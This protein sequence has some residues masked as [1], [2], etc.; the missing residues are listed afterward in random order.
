M[1][2][3][4]EGATVDV[5]PAVTVAW[6]YPGLRLDQ[7]PVPQDYSAYT[8]SLDGLDAAF[9]GSPAAPRFILEQALP[10]A[11]PVVDAPLAA[12]TIEC[13]Y[14]AIASTA[15]LSLGGH[16]GYAGRVAVSF[17]VVAVSP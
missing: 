3:A 1:L 16:S 13:R 6:S 11:G 14:R 10:K 2:A 17:Y 9:L 7:L 15:V 4:M 5:D 12:F 8:S